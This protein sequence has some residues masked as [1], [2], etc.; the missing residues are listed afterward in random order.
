M[1]NRRVS[2]CDPRVESYGAV[3]ELNAALGMARA[4]AGRDPLGE[5]L[6]GVQQTLI[7]LMGEL[8]T[9]SEDFPRYVRDGFP[10]LGEEKTRDLEEWVKE[11]ETEVGGF[12]G[13]VIPGSGVLAAA[14]DVARTACRNAERRVCVLLEAGELRNPETIVYLNRLSDLL[15]LLARDVESRSQRKA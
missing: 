6:A 12:K 10:Q 13:W 8:A 1:Y 7:A 14:L 2:K 9:A 15:W 4:H 5:R 11:L 3:D